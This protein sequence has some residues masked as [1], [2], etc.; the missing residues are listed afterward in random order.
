[1][2]HQMR[3]RHTVHETSGTYLKINKPL[4]LVSNAMMDSIISLLL[5]RLL[6]LNFECERFRGVKAITGVCSF[7]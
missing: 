7:S 2:F 4:T 1:M 6:A 3:L 5:D